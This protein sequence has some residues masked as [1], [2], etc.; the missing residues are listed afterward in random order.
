MVEDVVAWRLQQAMRAS[1][2]HLTAVLKPPQ[3]EG[4]QMEGPRSG[5]STEQTLQQHN[6]LKNIPQVVEKDLPAH[7]QPW[8]TTATGTSRDGHQPQRLLARLELRL[9]TP[10]ALMRLLAADRWSS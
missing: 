1:Q 8:A 9:L 2:S 7:R 3:M 10:K 4:P 6:T 5:A